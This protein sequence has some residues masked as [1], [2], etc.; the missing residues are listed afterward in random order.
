MSKAK[1]NSLLLLSTAGIL[2]VI[3]A[4]SLPNLTLSPGQSFSLGNSHAESH[5]GADDLLPGD[6][7]IEWL[8]RGI[9]GL[10]LVLL[11][12]YFLI[13]LLT[14]EGR[15][16]LMADVIVIAALFLLAYYLDKHPLGEG[17]Q[18]QEPAVSNPANLEGGP[19]LPTAVF[20]E[21]PPS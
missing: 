4:M 13:S 10:A 7:G 15:Q 11:P 9:I 20:S 6:N 18:L 1:R 3:L 17:N 12:L 2:V 5:S 19:E 8:F 16:R 14:S 21:D